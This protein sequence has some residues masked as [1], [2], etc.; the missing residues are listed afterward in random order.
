MNVVEFNREKCNKMVILLDL[1]PRFRLWRVMSSAFLI[2]TFMF[3][4][5]AKKNGGIQFNSMVVHRQNP[6]ESQFSNK[7]SC[8]DHLSST[9]A[10]ALVVR[11]R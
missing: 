9:V 2:V 4:S 11:G 10:Q 7:S 6:V 5:S 8:S 3:W 1:L